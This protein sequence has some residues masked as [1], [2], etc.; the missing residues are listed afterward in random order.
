LYSAPETKT[1]IYTN[2]I[3]IYSLGII[4]LE[5]LI[6]CKTDFEKF[7]IIDNVKKNISYL[8]IAFKNNQIIS[9]QYNIIIEKMI[10]NEKD[11]L[12]I[13]KISELLNNI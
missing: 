10:C 12:D 3:D 1:K 5:L 6:D 13:N 11:R 7:K 2:L 8:D 4:F 9:K